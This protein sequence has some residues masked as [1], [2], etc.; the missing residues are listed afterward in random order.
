[1]RA[2]IK[3]KGMKMK[4]LLEIALATFLSFLFIKPVFASEYWNDRCLQ[5]CFA[6]GH[7]CNFCAFECEKRESNCGCA[8]YPP[9]ECPLCD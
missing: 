5:N 1:M 2:Q 3:T 4:I 9:E 8:S 6:T 7:D